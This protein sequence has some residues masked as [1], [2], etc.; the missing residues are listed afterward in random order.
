MSEK[1]LLPAADETPMKAEKFRGLTI[2]E[3]RYQLL[4]TTLQKEFCKDKLMMTV[5]NAVA[6]T[7]FGGGRKS[8]GHSIFSHLLNGLSYA[9]YLLVGISA[10]KT[11]KSAL[12]LFRRGKKK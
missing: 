1:I 10:F 3:V 5:G 7:P 9:D 2:D 4:Y 8:S 11:V 12:R 6:A